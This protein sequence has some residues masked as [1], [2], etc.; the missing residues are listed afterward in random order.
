MCGRVPNIRFNVAKMLQNF[1]PIVDSTVSKQLFARFAKKP[2]L[3]NHI[4]ANSVHSP[5]VLNSM[6]QGLVWEG[7][8]R[9]ISS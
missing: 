9:T 3:G 5:L 4:S 7:I 1:I 6:E 2:T 8:S